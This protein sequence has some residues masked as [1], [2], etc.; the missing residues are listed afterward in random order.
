M[1]GFRR[2]SRE[3]P[4]PRVLHSDIEAVHGPFCAMARGDADDDD[5][6]DEDDGDGDDGHGGY[7]GD[8]MRMLELIPRRRRMCSGV[9]RAPCLP[10]S[11]TE[12][13][14]TQIESHRYRLFPGESARPGRQRPWGGK[15]RGASLSA[16]VARIYPSTR[17][18]PAHACLVSFRIRI[19]IRRRRPW[20]FTQFHPASGTRSGDGTRR[21]GVNKQYSGRSDP[22]LTLTCV[23][24]APTADRS[25]PS[26]F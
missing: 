22:T 4:R 23:R 19:R 25:D 15:V 6:E 26:Y 20:P 24:H 16:S 5:E 10:G 3:E 7:E 17:L 11:Q 1:E 9:A 21:R 13:P 8:Y 14:F 2:R 12:I 18:P